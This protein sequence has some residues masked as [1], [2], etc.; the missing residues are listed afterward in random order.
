MFKTL[1]IRNLDRLRGASRA[2]SFRLVLVPIL[3]VV[4]ACSTSRSDT[5]AY[6]PE[7]FT[8]PDA[9]S[10][11]ALESTYRI[12][13]LDKLAVN[14]FQVP[15]LSGEYQVDLAGFIAMP[16]LGNVRAVDKTSDELQAEISHLLSLDYLK[17]PDVT[18]GVLSATASQVTV[19]GS[20]NKPGLYPIFGKMTLLQVV[21]QSGGLDD[22][23]NPKRIAVFRQIDGVRQVAAFD[24]TTIRTGED[25]DP[26]IYRGDIIV[27]D[28]SK[29]KKAW[30]DTISSMPIL[31]V[32]RP[33]M[34]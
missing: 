16:L 6:N 15:D 22:T 7:G 17:D 19:E 4:S 34:L 32:F 23:A 1:A 30:R 11:M 9:P 21:A 24:L 31:N 8:A 14:V 27:V 25:T 3:A 12:G 26:A 20:V 10:A 33:F 29:T 5:M 2:I 28:G 13:P 18:V